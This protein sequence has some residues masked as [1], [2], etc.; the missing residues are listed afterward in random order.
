MGNAETP[1]ASFTGLLEFLKDA[2][3]LNNN[4]VL[5]SMYEAKKTLRK[6]MCV[7]IIV[8][9]IKKNVKTWT[10]VQC[11]ISLGGRK[12]RNRLTG[13]NVCR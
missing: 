7:Q 12:V 2:V 10:N 1:N 8:C 11:T 5:G 4:H 9:Y 6:D 13:E 3:L